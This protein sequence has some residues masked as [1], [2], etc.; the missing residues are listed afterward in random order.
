MVKC[1]FCHFDNEDGALFCDQCKSD[2]SNA[3][4]VV[5]TPVPVP[6]VPVAI[7]P[8]P[9][10]VEAIPVDDAGGNIVS[11]IQVEAIPDDQGVPLLV[12]AVP[13]LAEPVEAV[14]VEAV[15][16][17]PE[18][19]TPVPGVPE[20]VTPAPVIPEPVAPIAVEPV[21][22]YPEPVA[23][24]AVEPVPVPVTPVPVPVTPVEPV[25]TQP[26]SVPPVVTS[27]VPAAP[28]SPGALPDGAQPR[29]LVMRGLKRNVE[30]PI[31]EGPNF[32]GRADDKPVDID[33]E[34]QEPPDRV[35]CSRQHCCIFFEN[36]ELSIEDLNSSNGTFVNRTRIYPGQKTI[37]SAG[38]VVQ[39]GNV[40]MKVVV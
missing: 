33:L 6:P 27:P 10:A 31:F 38:D 34:E 11:P 16:I 26:E 19:V 3:A 24:I 25:P 17:V 22:V 29:L 4:P 15:P 23:P 20:P 18:P 32:V 9:I 2:L 36:N 28:A 12:E 30:Y 13:V 35:W 40:Q 39:I 1:P 21:P 7:E 14:P 8:I 37:L 5:P